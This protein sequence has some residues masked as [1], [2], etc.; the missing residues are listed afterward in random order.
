MSQTVLERT[1]EQIAD[2]AHQAARATDAFGDAIGA[3]GKQVRRAAKQGGDA[4]EEF[5]TETTERMPRHPAL[6]VGATCDRF[7]CRGVA[8]LD[9]T[10]KVECHRTS[11]DGDI[12]IRELVSFRKSRCRR[13]PTAG[14]DT[15]TFCPIYLLVRNP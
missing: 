13:L 9:G 15:A 5:L 1:A 6:T 8:R 12:D 11:I 4:A 3:G 7:H 2:S 10:A 14:P